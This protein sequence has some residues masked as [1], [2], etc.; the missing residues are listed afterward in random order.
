MHQSRPF[1]LQQTLGVVVELDSFETA[2]THRKYVLREAVLE[3][4]EPESNQSKQKAMDQLIKMVRCDMKDPQQQL[5]DIADSK[6]KGLSGAGNVVRKATCNMS[7]TINR[8]HA[9]LPL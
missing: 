3:N 9:K 2:S 6:H 1:I 8:S 5:M 4:T 7:A